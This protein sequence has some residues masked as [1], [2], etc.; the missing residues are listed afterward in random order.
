MAKHSKKEVA[1]RLEQLRGWI[2][3]GET[4]YTIVRSVSRS[5][6]SRQISLVLFKVGSDG[7]SYT[8][9]PNYAAS[10]VLGQRL[11]RNNGPDA[12]LVSGCGMDMAW[13]LV[14]YLSHALGYTGDAAL[15]KEAL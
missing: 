6:M 7:K 14:D 10:I 15:R 4:V 13:W 12:L 9:H 5:G 11:M 2:K 1:E 3:P 8:L